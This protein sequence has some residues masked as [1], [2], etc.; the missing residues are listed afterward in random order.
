MSD[1]VE[2]LRNTPNWMREEF[3]SWKS[4]MRSYDR[5]PFE[6]ADEIEKLRAALRGVLAYYIRANTS[7]SKTQKGGISHTNRTSPRGAGRKTMSDTSTKRAEEIAYNLQLSGVSGSTW[8]ATEVEAS[9]MLRALAAENEKLRA[10][11]QWLL[12]DLQDYPASARPIA[13]YDNARAALG[14]NQ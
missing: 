7:R 4:A 1:I 3:G 9:N 2:R 6:A 8:R 5:A 10:A 12:N 14:E 13:A 11:L